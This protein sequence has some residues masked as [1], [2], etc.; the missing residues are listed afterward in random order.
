[1]FV[2]RVEMERFVAEEKKKLGWKGALLDE[3]AVVDYL[4]VGPNSLQN[5]RLGRNH[6]GIKLA[7]IRLGKKNIKYRPEDVLQF[8]WACRDD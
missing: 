5:S 4:G 8:V 6:R 2:E 3:G 1:M 7:S